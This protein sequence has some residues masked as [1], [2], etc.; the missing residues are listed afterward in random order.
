VFHAGRLGGL[1]IVPHCIGLILKLA[2]T[3]GGEGGQADG[4]GE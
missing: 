2:R 1:A 4:G 3:S